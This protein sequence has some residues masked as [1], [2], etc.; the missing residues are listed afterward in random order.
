M[1]VELTVPS[2]GESITE[3]FIGTWHTSEGDRV[4]QDV[5][6][7]PLTGPATAAIAYK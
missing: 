5:E 4:E 2:V 6:F 7:L 1:A 3:V